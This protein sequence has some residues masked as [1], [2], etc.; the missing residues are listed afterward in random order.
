MQGFK[1]IT[2]CCQLS[3]TIAPS[4]V[5]SP[6]CWV[7]DAIWHLRQ[8]RVGV[9]FLLSSVHKFRLHSPNQPMHTFYIS[10][11]FHLFMLIMTE[12]LIRISVTNTILVRLIYVKYYVQRRK[13]IQYT[14]DKSFFVN[15]NHKSNFII[16]RAPATHMLQL[17]FCKRH[18]HIVHKQW[19][20]V[21]S[22]NYQV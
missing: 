13:F 20:L 15:I 12:R 5:Q 22:H 17:M 14:S 7:S 4:M 18:N 2:P 8:L 1:G 11:N 10:Q 19:A 21:G 6:V 16:K 3:P 9:L